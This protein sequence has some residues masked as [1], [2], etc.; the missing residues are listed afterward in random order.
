LL[1]PALLVCLLLAAVALS[2]CDDEGEEENLAKPAAHVLS[3]WLGV[4]PENFNLVG[5]E[6]VT[7][8]NGCLGVE[9]PGRVCSQ[10]QVPGKRLELLSPNGQS[11][12]VHTSDAGDYVWAP[13]WETE[14]TIVSVN[15]PLIEFSPAR[16]GFSPI[17]RV[18]PGTT[19]EGTPT[20]GARVYAAQ[21]S[22]VTDTDP[23][24]LVVLV[25]LEP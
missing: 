3:E 17:G 23:A 25:V 20:L 5:A 21:S 19:V 7:W 10:A 4:P 1:R 13:I 8:P 9:W 6:D 18:M 11:H 12:F 14:T 24:P 16:G 2:A 15:G 22:A